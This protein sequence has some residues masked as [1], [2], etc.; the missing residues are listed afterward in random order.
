MSRLPAGAKVLVTGGSS[1][2]GAELVRALRGRGHPVIVLARRAEGMG[3]APDLFPVAC[4]LADPAALPAVMARVLSDHPDLTVLVNNAGLQLARPLTDPALT[5]QDI[6][7]EVAVNLTAPAL[8]AQAVLPAMRARGRGWIVN[9]SSGL[10]VFPKENTA[11]YC[12]AKAG[13]S[14]LTTSLRWQ[15]EGQGITVAE[16]V[17]PLVDTPMT[18]GRG[19]GKI[20]AE[21]AAQDILR[22]LDRGQATIRIGKAWLLPLVARLAPSLGLGLMRRG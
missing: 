3:R 4:D 19:R 22:G 12:A 11:L 2:I 20:T 1:G 6:I 7:E 9:I 8:L 21:R 13:L 18:A 17:L 15:V 5:A 10:A 14:S 16:V